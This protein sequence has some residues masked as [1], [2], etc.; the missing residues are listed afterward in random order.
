MDWG[1]NVFLF[2]KYILLRCLLLKSRL[3]TKQQC[4]SIRT[5]TRA[6]VFPCVFLQG[7]FLVTKDPCNNFQC[8]GYPYFQL[9]K[10]IALLG[11]LYKLAIF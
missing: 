6:V 5:H 11:S 4:E 2:G 3:K 8:L 10:R 1:K 9:P 7:K